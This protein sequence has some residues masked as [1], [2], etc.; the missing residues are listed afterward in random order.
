MIE[1]GGETALV[2]GAASGIGAALAAALAA[3]AFLGARWRR[4]VAARLSTCQEHALAFD[5]GICCARVFSTRQTRSVA[6]A[7]MTLAP[8]GAKSMSKGE[9]ASL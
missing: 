9:A 2:T 7:G 4:A 6:C 3:R 1:Y 8:R 5:R